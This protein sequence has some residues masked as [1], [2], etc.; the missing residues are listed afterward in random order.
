MSHRAPQSLRFPPQVVIAALVLSLLATAAPAEEGQQGQ[1]WNLGTQRSGMTFPTEVAAF[2]ESCRGAHDFSLS[3]TGQIASVLSITGPTELHGIRRGQTKSTPARLDLRGAAPGPYEGEVVI[4]CLDCP[5]TCHLDHRTITVLLTVAPEPG[6]ATQPAGAP[7]AA[8]PSDAPAAAAPENET[9][10]DESSPSAPVGHVPL[11]SDPEGDCEFLPAVEADWSGEAGDGGTIEEHEGRH[12]ID[13]SP[14]SGLFASPTPELASQTR[15]LC[16][17]QLGPC[18]ELLAKVR[19]AEEAYSLAKAR[20]DAATEREAYDQAEAEALDQE[21]A[22]DRAYAATL[23]RQAAD[24]RQLAAD[25]RADAQRNRD[26]AKRQPRYKDSWEREAARDEARATERDKNAER[27]EQEAQRIEDRIRDKTSR[28]DARRGRAEA[29]RQA[30]ES[31]RQAMELA[32]KQYE[33]CMEQQRLECERR[34]REAVLAAMRARAAEAASRTPTATT[35]AGGGA[36]SPAGG[37]STVPAPV[38][39]VR[40]PAYESVPVQRAPF[41]QW[42]RYDVP[43]GDST[44]NVRIVRISGRD[45]PSAIEVRAMDSGT[46]SQGKGFE[47]HCKATTGTAV[48]LFDQ[49]SGDVK[50]YKLRVGCTIPE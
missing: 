41:C 15:E 9:P 17:D 6:A 16:I 2:N 43:F 32:R 40:Y 30:A 37:G 22:R 4:R 21:T 8:V 14:S 36:T 3:I 42:V 39:G 26:R 44:T 33:D 5:P 50:R 12:R 45:T 11:A 25:A 34:R 10:A 27:L 7:A 23:R 47:F 49:I 46:R 18:A 28:A 35:P 29:A 13:L 48:I 24:W 20:A 1:I 19:A 38:G 31:A